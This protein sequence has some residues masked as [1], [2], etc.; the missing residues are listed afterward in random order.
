[1]LYRP[2]AYKDIE[3]FMQLYPT[4]K[5]IPGLIIVLDA[6]QPDFEFE[7]LTHVMDKFKAT[8]HFDDLNRDFKVRV[9]IDIAH[10]AMWRTMNPNVEQAIISTQR[11]L[12]YFRTRVEDALCFVRLMEAEE[13]EIR[14]VG[15]DITKLMEE[16]M[17]EIL[18]KVG[19]LV[20][21]GMEFSPPRYVEVEI[22]VVT[23]Y[24]VNMLQMVRT[25]S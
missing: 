2:F 21:M 22:F 16:P 17:D 19:Y 8:G 4:V 24:R 13:T 18:G 12:Q 14:D 1:M 5:K 15:I 11:I 20:V 23:Y 3:Y 6:G 25:A 7:A 9:Y 10:H